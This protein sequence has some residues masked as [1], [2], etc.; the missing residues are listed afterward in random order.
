[1]RMVAALVMGAAIRPRAVFV[2]IHPPTMSSDAPGIARTEM[3]AGIRCY[4]RAERIVPDGFR[5]PPLPGHLWRLLRKMSR[6]REG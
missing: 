3:V 5:A 6:T 4:M 2:K 1:M